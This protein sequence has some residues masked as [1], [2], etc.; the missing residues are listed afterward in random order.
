MFVKPPFNPIDIYITDLKEAKAR[1][2]VEASVLPR[3]DYATT[4]VATVQGSDPDWQE[5]FC[6][7]CGSELTGEIEEYNEDEFRI[8]LKPYCNHC[9]RFII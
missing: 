1:E 6:P 8:I 7:F 2:L 9:Q 3:K 5:G 4:P